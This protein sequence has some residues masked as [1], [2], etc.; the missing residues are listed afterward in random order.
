MAFIKELLLAECQGV[1][2]VAKIAEACTVENEAIL[3]IGAGE[4]I[5]TKA[6]LEIAKNKNA[7]VIVIDPFEDAWGSIP[8]SYGKPYPFS[9]FQETTNS[10]SKYLIHIRKS[11]AIVSPLEIIK[12]V[13]FC[14]ID[15]LQFVESVIKD[16]ELCTALNPKVICLDDYERNTAISQVANGI[17]KFIQSTHV[18]YNLIIDKANIR[19]K[20][21]LIQ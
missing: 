17:D 5:N 12:P 13:S 8:E 9:K 7:N 4:G 14:F 11:S 1:S 19:R 16:L 10:L 20:A 21:Y 6:F 18:K 2:D 15:G 3:E